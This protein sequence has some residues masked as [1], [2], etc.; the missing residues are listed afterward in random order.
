MRVGKLMV[1]GFIALMAVQ[2]CSAQTKFT[3]ILVRY[4][5]DMNDRY[6]YTSWAKLDLNDSSKQ[7]TVKSKERPL[8]LKYEDIRE[9]IL[10][11]SFNYVYLEY[12]KTDGGSENY[13]FSVEQEIWDQVVEKFKSSFGDRISE[14]LSLIG[15]KIE[16]GELKKPRDSYSVNVDKQNRPMGEIKSD[17]ALIV[18]VSRPYHYRTRNMKYKY[19]L[20]ANNEVVAVYK[21]NNY[22]FFYLDPGEYVLASED[23]N[24]SILKLKVEAGKDYYLFQDAT[25]GKAKLSIHPKQVVL[26]ELQ[27]TYY[28]EWKK[29]K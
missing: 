18:L 6:M 9:I 19:R 5:W 27:G 29:K 14:G 11:P 25:A 28:A 4:I 17:K 21:Q 26:Y 2:I 8:N 24:S 7:L 15:T 10:E 23:Y 22:V 3:D 20:Q 1:A 16:K 13:M 12:R